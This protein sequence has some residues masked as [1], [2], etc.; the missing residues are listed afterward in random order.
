MFLLG[1]NQTFCEQCTFEIQFMVWWPNVMGPASDLAKHCHLWHTLWLQ[2]ASIHLTL[3]LCLPIS[4]CQLHLPHASFLTFSDQIEFPSFLQNVAKD[5]SS[6]WKSEFTLMTLPINCCS[7]SAF[8][9]VSQPISQKVSNC[10]KM[11]GSLLQNVFHV[12]CNDLDVVILTTSL[13][14]WWLLCVLCCSR[15]WGWSCLLYTSPSPRD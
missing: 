5:S 11:Q 4:L 15:P 8:C 3:S 1:L 6:R 10:T 14:F 2:A 12:A 9:K 13:W 7:S